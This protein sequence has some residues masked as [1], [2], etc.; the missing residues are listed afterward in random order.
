MRARRLRWLP[1]ALVGAFG[2]GCACFGPRDC[3]PGT[4]SEADQCVAADCLSESFDVWDDDAYVYVDGTPFGPEDGFSDGSASWPFLTIAEA[5]GPALARGVPVMIAPGHYDEVLALDST[6][7]GLVIRGMCSTTTSLTGSSGSSVTLD[8]GPDT[9]VR[10]EDL[11]VY[12]EAQA[13]IVVTSGLL[14]LDDV[15]VDRAVGSG[16]L[17]Q[18]RTARIEVGTA[19]IVDVGGG[20]DDAVPS[21]GLVAADG[22]V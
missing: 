21:Y 2:L 12:N 18:G 13:G 15:S 22:G 4:V 6:H 9:V 16:I 1:A 20:E 5:I 8:G 17:V 11:R 10:I 7:D 3:P 14:A 19:E